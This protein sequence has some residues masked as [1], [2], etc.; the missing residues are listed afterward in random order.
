MT[1]VGRS[2]ARATMEMHGMNRK[3][4]EERLPSNTNGGAPESGPLARRGLRRDLILLFVL[5]FGIYSWFRAVDAYTNDDCYFYL[6]IARNLATTGHQTFNGIYPTNGVHPLWTYLLAG[7][8][9]LVHRINPSLLYNQAYA[10]PLA[11]ALLVIGA[12]SFRR[13]A[14]NLRIEPAFIVFLPLVFLLST[15]VLYSEAHTLYAA[16]GVLT[17]LA[18]STL[19]DRRGGPVVLG[20]AAA[21]VMLARLDSVMFVGCF[22]LWLLGRW[23]SLPRAALLRN[24]AAFGVT[25]LAGTLP[26]LI[27]N[28]VLYG[29]IT[30][31]SGWLKSSFP[32][33][34]LQPFCRQGLASSVLGY[35]IVVGL[36]PISASLLL[37][38]FVWRVSR[39]TRHL[40][41]V[42][43]GGSL[44]HFLYIALFT[45]G[46]TGWFWYYVLPI[47]TFSLFL[48]LAWERLCPS[49]ADRPAGVLAASRAVRAFSPLLGDAFVLA[50]VAVMVL[51]SVAHCWH[52]QNWQERG[53]DPPSLDLRFVRE[54]H[55]TGQ[56]ILVSDYPGYLAFRTNNAVIAADML[57]GNFALYHRM[58]TAPDALA[59]LRQEAAHA[60][61]PIHYVFYQGNSWLV[62]SPDLQSLTYNDPR[63]RETAIGHLDVG[64]RLFAARRPNGQLLFAAWQLND[65]ASRAPSQSLQSAEVR[66]TDGPVARSQ[67]GDRWLTPEI[68]GRF[69]K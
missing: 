1:G 56:T 30:P 11:A 22:G 62:P 7:Y 13:A 57:T 3:Q 67:V 16:L 18:T 51:H 34:S 8:S 28:R 10:V 23:R 36:L 19:P 27:A 53:D 35:Q 38:P 59:F 64:H 6:V 55:I 21:L 63:T 48:S 41:L 31:I 20:A 9:Y 65:S 33:V 15:G 17:W 49:T 4:T 61:R 60:G 44:L 69:R 66:A 68:L 58:R 25:F 52:R 54:H 2:A 47:L 29:S 42:F 24:L 45:C 37:L 46:A 32:H 43:L 50:L 40:A 5:T 14:I 26:Y 39:R 12:L